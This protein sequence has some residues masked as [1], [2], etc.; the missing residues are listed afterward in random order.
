M[1]PF[2]KLLLAIL[3]TSSLASTA[4]AGGPL[5]TFDEYGNSTVN[6][7]P[8]SP[9]QLLPDPTGGYTLGNVLVYNL[10]FAGVQGDVLLHE[11]T[12]AD[13]FLDVVRFDGNFHLIFY[14]D[15]TDG[16]DAPADVSAP[17]NP[18]YPNQAHILEVGPEG[19]NYADY[20]PNP[21]QPGFDPSFPAY[22]F[23]S[24]VPEPGTMTL[25]GLGFTGL[26]AIRRRTK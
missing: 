26:L 24:D 22:Q 13:P 5:L 23:I 20:F 1:K 7:N 18:L 6:G 17:P 11:P 3:F 19:N 16:F 4:I 25:A 10:S 15:N 12:L 14:S 2:A 9:G 8:G 21:G